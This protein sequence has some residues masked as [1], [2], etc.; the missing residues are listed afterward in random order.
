MSNSIK[1]LH[2]PDLGG[3]D[4]AEV[5]EILVQVGDDVAIDT[6]LL[7]LEGEKA[8]MEIPATFAGKVKSIHLKLHD[9]VSNGD[10]LCDLALPTSTPSAEKSADVNKASG[11]KQ[12]HTITVPDIGSSEPVT[13]L[14]IHVT[15]GQKINAEEPLLTVEG[16]KATM[17][18]PSP[19]SGEITAVLVKENDQ[20]TIGSPIAKISSSD[21]METAAVEQPVSASPEPLQTSSPA[22]L[23][24]I[25]KDSSNLLAGPGVRRM[26]RNIGIDLHSI[27][28]SGNKG[29]ITTE[30]LER[31]IKQKLQSGQTGLGVE[32]APE[33]DFSQFGKI[34]ILPLSRIQQ[35]SG[36]NLHRNWVQIPHVTQFDEADITDLEAY[37]QKH[38]KKVMEKNIRLTPLVFM[39]KAVVH[40]LKT[41]PSFNCSLSH[42]HKSKVQKH[43]F[44]LGIAVDTPKGLV[45]PVIKDVD[46]KSLLELAEELGNI[47]KKARDKG[48]TV[49]EMQGSSMTISSLGG[50][51]GQYFTP[52]INA[53]D[54]AILGVSKSSIKPIHSSETNAFIPRLMLPLSLSYDHRVIDGAEG[55]RFMVELMKN[56][57]QFEHLPDEKS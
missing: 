33:I 52:I 7:T 42:D 56:L 38:K 24:P 2:I 17:E 37:R 44:H 36:K 48:L 8:T 20:L 32:S 9:I 35:Y 39:M 29:R 31:Y 18:I 53:P 15:K 27:Q 47:S 50:I 10:A 30:D 3:A 55:A 49:A 43:Y 34:D 13:L 4:S 28:G 41:I 23:T 12:E 57:Q 54:V 11:K 45:V 46:K 40:T 26:A 6:P 21:D 25:E 16:E 14:E 5:I 1:T 22:P 19:Y 51:G